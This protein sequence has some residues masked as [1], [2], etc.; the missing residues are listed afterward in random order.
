MLQT[1]T[2]FPKIPNF[3]AEATRQLV[4][5]SIHYVAGYL[6][7]KISLWHKCNICSNMFQAGG[8][9]FLKINELLTR[10]KSYK[11]NSGLY[12]VSQAFHYYVCTLEQKLVSTFDT[13]NFRHGIGEH[14]TN[15]LINIREP[16]T[17]TTFPK[18]KFITVL[19][20]LSHI[21]LVKIFERF[22]QTEACC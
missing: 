4:D 20:T 6:C 18:T 3:N 15:E 16:T 21:L 12:N 17:R 10:L 5:N 11:Q 13:D 2:P 7:K 14:I 9:G 22:A 1:A 8:L 19:C